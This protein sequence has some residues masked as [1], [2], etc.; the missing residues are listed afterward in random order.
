MKA[1]SLYAHF[2]SR[3]ALI[4]ALFHANYAAYGR[5]LAEITEG[6]GDFR[7]RLAA[8]V[9]A[10]CR[11]HD[12]DALLFG[13]LL[14]TQHRNLSDVARDARNPV[15]VLCRF[16]ASGMA[17][18]EVAA[19]DPVLLAGALIGVIVQP[20]TFHLYGRLSRGLLDMQ[21]ELV[22]LCLRLVG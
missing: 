8:M 11:L 12:E 22:A 5:T 20:A 19:G 1:S 18:G 6:T 7:T 17:S 13:F 4:G 10:I 2:A 9:R 3:E 15:E 21:E 14:L 16:V